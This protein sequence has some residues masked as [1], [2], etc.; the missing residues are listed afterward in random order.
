MRTRDSEIDDLGAPN[1]AARQNDIV[2]RNVAVDDA[3][4]V[5]RFERAADALAQDL[6]IGERQRS[7]GEPLGQ[8]RTVD[9]FH[10]EIGALQIGV[11]GKNEIAHDRFVLEIVKDRGLAPEQLENVGTA[12]KLRSNH[13]DRDRIAGLDIEALVD[14][15]HTALGDELFDLI[16]AI[17]ARAGSHA[18]AR[19]E[20]DYGPLLHGACAP[21]LKRI[22]KPIPRSASDAVP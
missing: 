7:R 18:A 13:L 15:S 16:D 17:Q 10:R 22:T 14:L 12:R 4:T 21:D 5:R 8:R 2:R 19:R 6:D 1:V 9:E 20:L 11:D 3:E